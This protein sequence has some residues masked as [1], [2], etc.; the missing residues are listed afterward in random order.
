[1]SR[2]LCGMKHEVITAIES[3]R[4]YQ[5]RRWPHHEHTIQEWLTIM[6][7]CMCDAWTSQS[8]TNAAMHEIRQVVAVGVAAMEQHGSPKRG[9][10]VTAP[11]QDNLL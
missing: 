8:G 6:Q 11:N 9:E 10:P 4:H 2:T 7:K 1:M 5:D 3:E